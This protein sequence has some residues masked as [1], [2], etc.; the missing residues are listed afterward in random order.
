MKYKNKF[1]NF[2][3]GIDYSKPQKNAIFGKSFNKNSK[4][5]FLNIE[6]VMSSN[7]KIARSNKGFRV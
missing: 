3:S 4:K 7:Q 5:I 2:A 1:T 6:F